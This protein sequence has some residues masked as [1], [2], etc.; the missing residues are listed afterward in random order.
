MPDRFIPLPEAMVLSEFPYPREWEVASRC[1]GEREVRRIRLEC[2]D[3]PSGEGKTR[4]L[5][6]FSSSSSSEEES[7]PDPGSLL[8][9]SASPSPSPCGAGDAEKKLLKTLFNPPNKL[10]CESSLCIASLVG[11]AY[12]FFDSPP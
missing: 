3:S 12:G 9:R 7:P 2:R 5:P 4:L 1:G 11:L 6:P 10:A 8:V